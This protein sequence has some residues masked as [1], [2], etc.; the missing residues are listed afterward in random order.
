MSFIASV[1]RR[2]WLGVG[3]KRLAHCVGG[4]VVDAVLFPVAENERVP[5]ERHDFLRVYHI[6]AKPVVNSTIHL[7]PLAFL[8]EVVV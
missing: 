3:N 5:D 8:K 6:V 2:L 1:L 4:C 7:Y